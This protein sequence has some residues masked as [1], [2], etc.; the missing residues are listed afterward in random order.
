MSSLRY[1][2]NTITCGKT[3]GEYIVN[4]LWKFLGGYG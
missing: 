4:T 1:L 3:K 2:E